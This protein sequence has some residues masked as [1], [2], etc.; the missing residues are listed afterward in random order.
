[1]PDEHSPLG[2]S[3]LSR[4]F[5][6]PGSYALSQ[7]PEVKARGNRTSI[8]SAKGTFAHAIVERILKD[9]ALPEQG[10]HRVQGHDVDFDDDMLSA[11]RKHTDTLETSIALADWYAIEQRV[12]LDHLWAPGKP[13]EPIFGTADFMA[14]FKAIKRLQVVDYKHGAGVIVDIIDNPQLLAYAAGGIDIA[15]GPVDEIELVI[16]QPNAS[17]PKVKTQIVKRID[18]LMW[19]GVVL[20]PKVNRVVTDADLFQDGPQCRFCPCTHVCPRLHAKAIAEAQEAF[21]DADDEALDPKAPLSPVKLA[22]ALERAESLAIWIEAIR[23]HAKDVLARGE[24]VPGWKLEATSR[25]EWANKL[26]ARDTLV[27]CNATPEDIYD[28][29]S[30]AQI[31]KVYGLGTHAWDLV[32][33]HIVSHPGTRLVRDNT[34][35]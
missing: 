29:K 12:S 7:T 3:S 11:V 21:R 26:A 33:Q 9:E 10:M 13:P 16:V 5:A 30:P 27:S 4:I 19:I 20:V 15:P 25:R 31:A 1:M 17:G 8:H 14:Y 28:L 22:A 34:R 2:P 23:T 32:S 18:L 6:C 35:S 24:L